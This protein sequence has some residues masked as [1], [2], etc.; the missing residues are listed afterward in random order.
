MKDWIKEL[1][2]INKSEAKTVLNIKLE[3]LSNE[4][5]KND[6]M[7]LSKNY[8]LELAKKLYMLLKP[9]DSTLYT[10]NNVNNMMIRTETLKSAEP[11]LTILLSAEKDFFI[12]IL[13]VLPNLKDI[14]AD[15]TH[16]KKL[17][18]EEVV[19]ELENYLTSKIEHHELNFAQFTQPEYFDKASATVDKNEVKDKDEARGKLY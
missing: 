14:K 7:E 12:E 16:Y 3:A 13:P 6:L 1:N 2:E 9:Y 17:S 8:K 5:L 19:K 15:I 18:N 10:K 4:K 11:G